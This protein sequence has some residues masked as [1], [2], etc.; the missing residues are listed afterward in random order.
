MWIPARSKLQGA[1]RLL[2]VGEDGRSV[3]RDKHNQH[4]FLPKSSDIPS[5]TPWDT[6][7]KYAF[8]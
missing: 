2:R 8:E 3:A 1:R 5:G 7:Y 6:D 4:G